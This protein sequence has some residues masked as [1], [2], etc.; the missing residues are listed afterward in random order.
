M[1]EVGLVSAAQEAT[2]AFSWTC[3]GCSSEN[4]IQLNK[5]D[6][7]FFFSNY[8]KAPLKFT[9]CGGSDVAGSALEQ[10]DIDAELLAA[11]CADER[12]CFSDQDEDIILSLTQFEFLAKEYQSEGPSSRRKHQLLSAMVIKLHDD[13]FENSEERAIAIEFLTALKGLW[14]D[15]KAIPGYIRKGAFG[16]I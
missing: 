13:R 16:K 3:A 4:A 5:F 9:R 2:Y 7:A 6:S 14:K 15:S 12:L 10:P 8:R 1:G 11:W